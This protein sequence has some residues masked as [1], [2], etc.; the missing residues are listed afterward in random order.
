MEVGSSFDPAFDWC[1]ELRLNLILLLGFLISKTGVKRVSISF[2]PQMLS[3]AAQCRPCCRRCSV[4]V[5]KVVPAQTLAA[6][7]Q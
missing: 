6:C 4:A 5:I 2:A 3:C 7:S 1:C